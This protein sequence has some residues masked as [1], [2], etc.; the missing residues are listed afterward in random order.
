MLQSIVCQAKVVQRVSRSAS[1][2]TSIITQ[3]FYNTEA[4]VILKRCGYDFGMEFFGMNANKITRQ[5]FQENVF[6]DTSL[7]WTERT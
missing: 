2:V 5:S 1:G 6:I 7:A 3:G 4:G